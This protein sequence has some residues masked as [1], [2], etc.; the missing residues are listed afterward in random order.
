M[1]LEKNYAVP[2]LFPHK[3]YDALYFRFE[4]LDM[5]IS[6]RP[7]VQLRRRDS[8]QVGETY[9]GWFTEP[10]LEAA[11]CVSTR[12]VRWC[13]SLVCLR[14]APDGFLAHRAALQPGIG[15]QS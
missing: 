9:E 11:S 6:G 14:W 15:Y 12:P 1:Q 3:D 13:L 2:Y 4:H 10:H 7:S 5:A 8:N